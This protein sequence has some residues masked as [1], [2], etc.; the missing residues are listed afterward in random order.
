M[1]LD[2]YLSAKQH[3]D[4]SD[5]VKIN[6]IDDVFG[7][8]GEED[9]DYGA[10]EGTFHVAYWRKANA[11]HKWFVNNV[12]KGVDDCGEYNVSRGQLSELIALCEQI[13]AEP[14]KGAEMMPTASGFLFGSTDYDEFYEQGVADTA[15]MLKEI[16]SDPA[17]EK[18]DF[19]YRAS[20]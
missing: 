3:L 19:Y 2:M 8:E 16:L 20:W 11:I 18:A 5:T 9:G 15:A 13:I 17:L 10:K 14:K 12:Q 1:G 4:P 6:I 7:L